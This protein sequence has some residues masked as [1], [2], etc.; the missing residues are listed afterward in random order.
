MEIGQKIKIY[1]DPLTEST[2]EGT[3]I[4]IIKST[5][6]ISKKGFEV[7]QVRF[8]GKKEVVNRIVHERNI[9]WSPE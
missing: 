3:A 7:W 9:D 5:P 1:S 6:G 8:P 2:L 4:L